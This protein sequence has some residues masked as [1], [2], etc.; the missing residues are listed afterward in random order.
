[1]RLALSVRNFFSRRHGG[2]EIRGR[3]APHD[4]TG[5]GEEKRREEKRGEERTREE[6]RSRRERGLAL[7]SVADSSFLLPFLMAQRV[8]A[9]DLASVFSVAP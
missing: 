2:T 6:K 4:G 5:R 8:R 9:K 1:V 7:Y 3:R